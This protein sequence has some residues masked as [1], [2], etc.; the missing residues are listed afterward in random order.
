MTVET[1]DRVP[2]G[3]MRI[4]V[5]SQENGITKVVLDG[6]MD[7][8]G[9][10]EV[11]PRFKEISQTKDKVIVDLA[12]VNFLASLGMRTL[13]MSA[14]SLKEKGGQL[15]L[16]KPQAEVEKALRSAGLDQI[17]PLAS[18]LAAATALFR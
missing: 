9:S 13:V 6:S 18:D 5:V 3:S 12:N 8:T 7:I 15:V 10:L 1:P 14:K 2:E 11:D 17:I 4:E 16:V